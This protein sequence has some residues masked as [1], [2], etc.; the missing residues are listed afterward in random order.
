MYS[1]FGP[2]ESTDLDSE[3][4]ASGQDSERNEDTRTSIYGTDHVLV[5]ADF[6]P[7]TTT[8]DLEKLLEN[9][10]DKGFVIRW[11]NDTIA[12]AVFPTRA[13]DLE[14]PRRRPKTSAQAA[15]RLIAYG[16]GL[17]LPSTNFGS[18]ELREQ[19][20]ARKN[21]IQMR[22]NLRDEAWGPDDVN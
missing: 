8:M 18:K 7:T 1:D 21:R 14:P 22:Q 16:M 2:N 3:G 12:L 10:E 6:P 11:V 19:E 15:K 4:P 17:K 13:S 20:E 9:C 5:L